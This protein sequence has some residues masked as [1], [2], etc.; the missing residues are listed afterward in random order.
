VAIAFS[1]PR[2]ATTAMPEQS[3]PGSELTPEER[4]RQLAALLIPKT[5]WTFGREYSR[6]RM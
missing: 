3:S 1:R 5:F 6:L 2:E 4:L